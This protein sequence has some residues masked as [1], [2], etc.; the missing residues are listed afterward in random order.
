MVEYS[1]IPYDVV[2]SKEHKELALEATRKSIV[3]LKNENSLLP[4]KKNIGTIAVI[5]PNSD[6]ATMLLGNYNGIPSDPVT[7]LRGIREKLAGIS[8]VLYAQGSELA[9]GIPSY[10]TIPNEVLFNDENRNGLKGNYYTDRTFEGAVSSKKFAPNNCRIVTIMFQGAFGGTATTP[11]P[12][13]GEQMIVNY[14]NV[15]FVII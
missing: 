15:K 1:K 4:L 11:A 10:N 9:D 13:S 3:L 12:G 2:D 14:D 7:P 5:G 6:Q 8:K